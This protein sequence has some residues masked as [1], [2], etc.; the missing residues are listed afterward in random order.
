M[1]VNEL[2]RDYLQMLHSCDIIENIIGKIKMAESTDEEKK[3]AVGGI[4][5]SLETEILD[6]KYKDKDLTKIRTVIVSFRYYWN[7]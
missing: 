5:M 1:A 6:D 4:I 2:E 7:S 3:G